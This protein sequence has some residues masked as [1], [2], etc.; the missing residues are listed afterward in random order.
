MVDR[1]QDIEDNAINLQ[2]RVG[3]LDE[4]LKALDKKIEDIKAAGIPAVKQ[5]TKFGGAGKKNEDSPASSLKKTTLRKAKV[6]KSLNDSV[7]KQSQQTIQSA[8]R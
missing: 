6:D 2:R 8:T 4:Q 5:R 3:G 1:A 7:S